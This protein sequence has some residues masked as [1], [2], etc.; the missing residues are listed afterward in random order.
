MYNFFNSKI[1]I[2]YLFFKVISLFWGSKTQTFKI[3]DSPLV[4]LP[5]L[6]VMCNYLQKC[7]FLRTFSHLAFI[8]PKSRE[9][10]PQNWLI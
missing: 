5:N 2:S 4:E 1:W 10:A 3:R 9:V 6:L 7:I 8:G